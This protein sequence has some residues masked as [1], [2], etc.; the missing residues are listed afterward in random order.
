MLFLYNIIYIFHKI[1]HM[2]ILHKTTK[3]TSYEYSLQ[4]NL[5][6]LIYINILQLSFLHSFL[7]ECYFYILSY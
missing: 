6:I 4:K 5:L 3:N 7:L 1:A 2:I